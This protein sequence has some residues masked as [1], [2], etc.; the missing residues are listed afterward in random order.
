MEPGL[1]SSLNANDVVPA[2]SG[3]GLGLSDAWGA[4][5]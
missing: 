5:D 3:I 4:T 2:L 1:R